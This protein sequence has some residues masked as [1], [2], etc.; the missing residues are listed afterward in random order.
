MEYFGGRNC[1]D[2][3]GVTAS[4]IPFFEFLEYCYSGDEWSK[5]ESTC[6]SY[7]YLFLRIYLSRAMCGILQRGG[8]ELFYISPF[9]STLAKK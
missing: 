5:E 9:Y 3:W 7:K 1:Y 2:V 8:V 4:S 6:F